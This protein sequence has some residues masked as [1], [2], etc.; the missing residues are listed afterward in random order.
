MNNNSPT[1]FFDQLRSDFKCILEILN[2]ENIDD[3]INIKNIIID[4]EL[5]KTEN[6]LSITFKN[7]V[8]NNLTLLFHHDIYLDAYNKEELKQPNKEL[9]SIL[10]EF[11]NKYKRRYTRLIDLIKSD[12]KIY[13]FHSIT[14]SNFDYNNTNTFEN[15]IKKINK[16]TNY[17][18]VLFVKDF[19]KEPYNYIIFNN[20]I[21]INL[22]NFLIKNQSERNDWKE[23]NY[24]WKKIF[25]LIKEKC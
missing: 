25:Q 5:Y 12:K 17:V 4:K 21:K 11:I 16:N 3:I 14:E 10:I 6:S 9:N 7:F 8:N 19:V 13:F 18:L 15:I 20:Y 1:N 24:D 23:S 22:N 2:I